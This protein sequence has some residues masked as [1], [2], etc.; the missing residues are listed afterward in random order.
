M[1]GLY[2]LCLRFHCLSFPWTLQC[3]VKIVYFTFIISS[4]L[5]HQH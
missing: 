3:D 1:I 5:V 4:D 2:K